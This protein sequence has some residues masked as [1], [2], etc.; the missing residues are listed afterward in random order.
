MSICAQLS[1]QSAE[2]GQQRGYG[3]PRTSG[4]RV[5]LFDNLYSNFLAETVRNVDEKEGLAVFMQNRTQIRIEKLV[6]E[7][8]SIVLIIQ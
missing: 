5:D 1:G 6:K 7:Q 8:V 2:C 3:T 4:D